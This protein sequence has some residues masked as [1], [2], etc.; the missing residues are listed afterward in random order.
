MNR[1]KII[2][3]IAGILVLCLFLLVLASP[4]RAFEPMSGE[5]VVIEQGQVVEDDL[6]VGANV[7][8]LRGTIE[9][10]LVAAGSVIVIDPSGVVTGDILVGAQGVVINGTVE[11]DARVAGAVISVGAGAKIGEDLIAFGYGIEVA[12]G[13]TVGHDL[14]AFGSQLAINGGVGRNAL[15]GGNGVH[16]SGVI[17]GDVSVDVGTEEEA[18]PFNPFMFMQQQPEMPSIPAVPGG[19]TIDP[20]AKIGGNL[21]YTSSRVVN[22]PSGV[23]SGEV[24]RHVPAPPTTG[25]KAPPPPP[26]PEEQIGSWFIRLLRSLATLYIMG[27]LFSWLA[28]NLLENGVSA[29]RIKPWQSLLWGIVAYFAFFFVLF[30]VVVIFIILVVFLAAITL[31]DLAFTTV[32]AGVVAVSSLLLMFKVSI[33]YL[34]KIVV[35]LLVGRWLLSRFNPELGSHRFWPLVLG[36][37]LFV[38]IWSIPFIGWLVNIVVILFGLGALWILGMDWQRAWMAGRRTSAAAEVSAEE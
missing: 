37:F 38:L 28:P 22:I 20:G 3:R 11:G 19:L 2:Q 35:S 17:G 32:G 8:I 33:S 36:I 5:R 4:A 25:E 1:K 14:V 16:I 26:T 10:D 23:V 12:E 15:V 29:L 31:G 18:L 30:V 6:Y 24:T 27:F 13:A 9:G 34:A 21:S 7:F